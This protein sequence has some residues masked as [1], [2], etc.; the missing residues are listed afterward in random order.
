MVLRLVI[1][2]LIFD[3]NRN[4][5]IIFLPFKPGIDIL[6]KNPAVWYFQ[7]VKIGPA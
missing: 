3:K 5:E 4:F 2:C 1:F 7:T 6:E